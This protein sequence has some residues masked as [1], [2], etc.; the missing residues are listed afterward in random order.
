[1]TTETKIPM[2]RWNHPSWDMKLYAEPSTT[3]EYLFDNGFLIPGEDDPA[4][5][6]RE[7][8]E[9][10]KAEIDALPEWDG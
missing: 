3:V 10:T 7:D 8:L 9:M 5:C 2:A 1:M 6:I 4:L